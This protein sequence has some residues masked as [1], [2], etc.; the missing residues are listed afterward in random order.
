[1]K[2]RRG[3][4]SLRSSAI[5]L[6]LICGV[7]C[8]QASA[9]IQ[10]FELQHQPAGELA[11]MVRGLLGPQARVAAHENTLVVNASAAELAEI[12]KLVESYDRT[13]RMLRVTVE[14]GRADKTSKRDINASGRISHGQVTVGAGDQGRTEKPFLRVDSG[15]DQVSVR[16]QDDSLRANR[17]VSQFISVMEGAP[18]RISVGRAV[19]FTSQLRSYCRR[20]PDFV[21][22][23]A[24]QNVDTGFE[25]LPRLY[26]DMVQLDI[27]PFL[28]FLDERNPHQIVFQEA[29][30]QV[31]IPVGAWYD[32]GGQIGAQAGLN[33]E[34]L[35]MGSESV[36]TRNLIRLR[37]DPQ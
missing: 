19:P 32:L 22:T 4:S 28:A 14:Q 34:I 21:E 13:R 36:E 17:Q 3:A 29:S 8:T 1:M 6:A 12:A 15:R 25:V 31:R 30:S 18:A 20:H 9:A 16:V 27:R 23:T 2:I 7:F 37:V 24:Y 35:G 5:A 33:R 11:E 10:V 26:G